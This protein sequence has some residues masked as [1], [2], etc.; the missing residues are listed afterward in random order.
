MNAVST[1]P[2]TGLSTACGFRHHNP[3]HAEL[4]AWLVWVGEEPTAAVPERS[5]VVAAA[6]VPEEALP[7]AGGGLGDPADRAHER[8]RRPAPGVPIGL[9]GRPDLLADRGVAVVLPPRGS[10]RQDLP[11]G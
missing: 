1:A 4:G 9:G 3:V 8:V 6:E 11:G 10:A 7:G 5:V 2:S